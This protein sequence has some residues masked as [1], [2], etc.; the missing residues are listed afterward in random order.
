[1]LDHEQ[2]IIF[3]AHLFPD[4]FLELTFAVRKGEDHTGD[5]SLGQAERDG[6]LQGTAWGEP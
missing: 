2:I 4:G 6:F 3:I 1:M 5:F